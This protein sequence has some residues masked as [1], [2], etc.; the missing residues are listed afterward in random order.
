MGYRNVMISSPA[1]LSLK[2]NQLIVET[3]Q[4]NRVP[5]EDINSLLIENQQVT[6]TVYTL[7]KLAEIGVCVFIC[8]EKHI[9]SAVMTGLN[10]HSRK[11]KVFQN[12]ISMSKPLLKNM[13][14][15]IV[16]QKILNQAG[17]LKII[18]HDGDKEM[19]MMAKRVLSG[20]TTNIEATAASF[21]FKCLFGKY[22]T[23]SEPSVMNGALNYGYAILRG[24][25]ARTLVVYGFEPCLG[26]FHHSQLNA[27]NLADDLIEIYRPVVDLFVAKNIDDTIE[28][29]TPEL[30]RQLYNLINM[31]VISDGQYCS[32][33]YAIE[34]TVQSLSSIYSEKEGQLKL[35]EIIPLELHEYE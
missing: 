9:P 33:S 23:R 29:L 31:D 1:K 15:E 20:D 27:F 10:R 24:L 6:I 18:E 14:K 13:W 7:N 3:H 35:C 22:F 8:N 25:I 30:K 12:Q 11:L 4:K 34:R 5:L 26:I 17:V 19:E 28:I 32:V 16:T 21:Y 2:E